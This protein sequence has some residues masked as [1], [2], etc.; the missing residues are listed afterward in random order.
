VTVS[1]GSPLIRRDS[2]P[3]ALVSARLAAVSR[4][5]PGADPYVHQTWCGCDPVNAVAISEPMAAYWP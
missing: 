4:G 2:G 1:A 3:N 5:L